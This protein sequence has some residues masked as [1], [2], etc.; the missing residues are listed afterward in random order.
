MTNQERKELSSARLKL[1][2][3]CLSTAKSNREIGDYRASVNRTYYA[4]FHAM[5]AALALDEVDMSKHSGIM[6]EFRK[7]YLKTEILDRKLSA[8]IT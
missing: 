8:T 4:V 3:D 2:H 1:A 6:A 5:R 7:R